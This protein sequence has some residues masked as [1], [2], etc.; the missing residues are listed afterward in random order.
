MERTEAITD[1]PKEENR[2]SQVIFQRKPT[3]IGQPFTVFRN[4]K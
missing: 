4:I 3:I 2:N 1:K